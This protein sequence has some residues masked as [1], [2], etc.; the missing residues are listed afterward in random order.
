MRARALVSGTAAALLV[1][2]PGAALAATTDGATLTGE[3]YL[4]LDGDGTRDGDEPG[5]AAVQLTLRTDATILD[6]TVTADDGTW[7]FNN[8]PP[9]TVTLVVEPP[10]DHVITGS[11]VPGLSASS[12]EATVEVSDDAA[13]G[14]VGLGSPVSSG[15][16]VAATVTF[17]EDAS[18]EDTYSWALTAL[19]LGPDDA[20]GP[21]DLRAVL[22]AGHEVVDAAGDGWDCE[23]STAIVLCSTAD[24]LAAG[25]ALPVVTL[26]TAAVGDVGTTVTTTGTVRLEGVFD[27]AP[28]NDEDVASHTIGTELAAEDIDGDGTGDLTTAGVRAGGTLAVALFALA[29]GAAAVTASRR[30]VRP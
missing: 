6:A 8:V 28:L 4:D 17:V 11:T 25:T 2:A 29:V 19:N 16:D 30:T 15:P 13:L 27:G 10:N 7:T 26:T 9:G 12:G 21:V 22:S 3:V 1:L 5:R 23:L 18:T 20:D 24:D 14:A